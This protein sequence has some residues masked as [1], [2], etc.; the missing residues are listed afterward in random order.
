MKRLEAY[1]LLFFLLIFSSYAQKHPLSAEDLWKMKRVN[2]LD[3]SPDGKTAAFV[4][5]GYEIKTN[6]GNGDIWFVD[7]ESGKSWQFTTGKTTEG[8]PV[9][10][11]DGKRLAF[12]A[13]RDDNEKSQIYV[14]NVG[15]GEARQITDMPLGSG[16]PKWFPDGKRI[17]FTSEMLPQFAENFDSLRAE[18]KRRK[19]SRVSALI[20]ENRLYR[21]WDHYLTDGTL[22]HIYS[23]DIETEKISDLTPS[24][25]RYFNGAG[26]GADFDI[27]P[28]GKEIVVTALTEGPPYNSLFTDIYTIPTD[29]SGVMKNLTADN[30][31]SDYSPRYSLDGKYIL[32]G[33]ERNINMN[34][35]NTKLMRHD[36]KT[37]KEIELCVN[38]DRSPSGWIIGDG[39]K[40][41]YFTAEDRAKTS[42]F[43]VPMSGGAVTEVLRK[44][45]NANVKMS[46]SDLVFLH[47]HI[48]A[49]TEVYSIS[50]SGKK[51][52]KLTAFNDSLLARR[53]MGRV[54]D[55]W[56][57]GADGDSVQAY[58]VYPPDFD[59]KKKWPL[60]VLVHGG[61][62]GTFGDDFHYRWNHML[63]AS[64]GY[65]AIA[66]NF[67]G[68]TSFG[69]RFAEC[70]NGAHPEKPFIDIM[71]SVDAMLRRG[72]ID[73]TRMA[74]GG[75]SYGGFMSAWI[76]SHTDRFACLINHAGVYN[77]MA[78]FASDVTHGRHISY[79]GTPWHGRDNVLRWSPSQYA[80][81]Y[82][83]PTLVMHGEKDYRVPYS[84]GLELYGMLTAKK[85]PARLVV[86]PDENHWILSAQNSIHW[87][88]EFFSWLERW[89][90]KGG[91]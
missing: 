50:T 18:L 69:E 4:V 5:T 6:K 77:L 72:F 28:D 11:P 40:T 54:E 83:T 15:G 78:Q 62:H 64:P 59:P 27:S 33:K 89:V 38:F 32:Y 66:P 87:Y 63:F 23:V 29:G 9:W 47:Q 19:D 42:I 49:P 13:K 24:M 43:S 46:A 91:Q 3:V 90:G 21:Y 36:R 80:A 51:L 30:P 44:G 70:I 60:L 73:S 1:T 84:Q 35:E 68:S 34:A 14:I 58:A 55:M 76:G 88:S 85:V 61:P 7:I 45:S 17:G 71:A 37:G 81:G 67:H 39:G 26:G 22:T 12:V 48:S 79:G 20:T 16:N 41:V 53:T 57:I 65:V 56:F 82:S 31:A 10:S 2:S 52:R 86:Y 74:A 25:N 8:S 75:G